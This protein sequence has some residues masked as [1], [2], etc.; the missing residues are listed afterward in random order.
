MHQHNTGSH[1]IASFSAAAAAVLVLLSCLVSVPAAADVYKYVD[2]SGVIHFSNIPSAMDNQRV[3]REPGPASRASRQRFA[4]KTD[5]SQPGGPVD[6]QKSDGQKPENQ[7]PDGQKTNALNR[8]DS[9]TQP[10]QP[11]DSLPAPKSCTP[12]DEGSPYSDIIN[13]KCN[14][15]G[16]DPSLVRSIIHAES[17]FNQ[18]AVSNK[19]AKGLMQLMPSTASDM[20]VSR[21]FD[22]DQ[23]IEGGVKYLRFLLD[24]FAGDVELSVAAYNCGQGKVIKNGNCVPDIKE[25]KNYVKKVMRLGSNPVTGRKFTRPIYKIELKDGSIM[26]TD[27]PGSSGKISLLN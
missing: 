21:I 10:K 25:T 2:D 8:I 27:S 20:G 1:S 22:A 3:V 7:K 16:V 6:S 15:Y 11:A 26:F 13:A 23:N 18:F 24:M 5:A 17:N 14:K 9:R 4:K 19:G 12:L